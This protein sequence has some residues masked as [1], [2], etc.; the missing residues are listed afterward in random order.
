VNHRERVVTAMRRQEPDRVPLFYRDVPEVEAR[1]LRDLG[2]PDRESLLR[3]FDIDFRWVEPAYVGPQLDD[4]ATGNRRDIWGVESHYVPLGTGAGYWEPVR[5][6]LA[7]CRNAAALADHPWPR[8]EWFDFDTLADQVARYEGYAIMTAP[9]YASPGILQTPAQALLGEERAWTD[10]IADPAFFD[11]LVGRVLD[12]EIPFIEAMMG[13]AGGHID[14][15]RI[16]DD[17][18]TQRGLLF[19]PA[20]YRQ[21]IRP[22]LQA[23]AGAAKRHGAWYYHHS[24]GA[25]RDLIPALIETGVDVLDPVQVKAAG[26][27]PA[28]LKSEFGDRL[29][30]SGGVDEQE[31]LPFGRPSDVRE[32]VF[33][34][35]DDMARGGGFILGP[36]HN[37]QADI[38]TENIVA[39]YEAAAQWRP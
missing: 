17:F 2:L 1:L 7:D 8:L 15:F 21:R 13:A 11:A 35:L 34:L 3:R 22:A 38:P 30:F 4:P 36:T 33:R 12:F 16:G 37:L 31:L 25:V 28:E 9:G 39:L 29:V 6:P 10:L 20:Q 5:H 18:G 23:M 14:F 24:C 26:M 27:V 32:A 19:G